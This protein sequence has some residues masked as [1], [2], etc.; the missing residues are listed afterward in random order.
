MKKRFLA[1]ILG[2]ILCLPCFGL[3]QE[4]VKVE[5]TIQGLLS[6]CAGETC[7]PREEVIIAAME[8]TFVL[9]SDE[10]KYYLL[11]NIKNS[12]LSRYL[13]DPVK[14]SG[15]LTLEGT[16]LQVGTAE[17]LE[18]GEWVTFWSPEIE[19]QIEVKRESLKKKTPLPGMRRRTRQKVG[20]GR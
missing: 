7:T 19:E 5:G 11:P 4:T 2:T 17:V 8:D 9:V 10:G 20:Q 3:A 16:A 14:V 12:V 18:R 6:T 13:N 1:I 15:F